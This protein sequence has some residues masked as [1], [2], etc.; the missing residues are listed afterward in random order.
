MKKLLSILLVCLMLT[1]LLASC[2]TPVNNNTDTTEKESKSLYELAVEAGFEGTLEEWCE[3]V[4]NV[5]DTLEEKNESSSQNN[6]TKGE[7]ILIAQTH[8]FA[9][10]PPE[11]SLSLTYTAEYIRDDEETWT[12]LVSQNDVNPK[13]GEDWIIKGGGYTYVIEKS[14]GKILEITL[15]E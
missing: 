7:A 15:G 2:G 6:I 3:A 5:N 12:I 1:V 9:V 13:D 10:Q 14:T 4:A 8:L 11:C